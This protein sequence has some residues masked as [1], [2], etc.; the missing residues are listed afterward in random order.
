MGA[1][2]SIQLDAPAKEGMQQVLCPV[3]DF[4]YTEFTGVE[5]I[6][7]RD[8]YEAGWS[9]RGD[10]IRIHMQCEAGH[11]FD[12]CVGFHKGNTHVFTEVK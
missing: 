5:R 12:I 10:L 3:C 11:V 8:N 7:S 1:T 4:D 6:A 2:N 9:G